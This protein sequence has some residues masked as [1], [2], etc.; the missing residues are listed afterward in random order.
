MQKTFKRAK[1]LYIAVAHH[2]H[3]IYTA[4]FSPLLPLLIDKLQIP[5]SAVAV[6]H[7]ARN[8]PSLLNPVLALVAERR[9]V[10]YFVIF[11]PAVTAISMSLIG[12][13]GSYFF[14]MLLLLIAGFSAALFHIPSPVMIRDVS[15]DRVGTGMSYFMVG[16]ELARTV[17]PIV[18]TA[19]VSWWALEGIA[20]LMPLGILTS[21]ILYFGLRNYSHL[22]ADEKPKP[23]AHS[24]DILK[25]YWTFFAAIALYNL[26]NAGMKTA[27]TLY[28]PVYLTG[29]G[30]SL[31][32]AGSSLALLQGFGVVGVF[33][34]G[35]IS[36]LIGRRWTLGV[37]SAGTVV[38]MVLFS[39]TG[40]IVFLCFLGFFLFASGPVLMAAVQD[41]DTAMPTFMN[42]LYM[43]INFGVGSLVALAVGFLGDSVGLDRTYLY[44]ALFGIGLVP[45]SLLLT[46]LN[47][48]SAR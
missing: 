43:T 18:A 22:K 38:F 7:V 24:I 35:R 4:F 39:L 26:F 23:A 25:E 36:D 5:L 37:S 6:L 42:G 1:V 9:G 40:N 14:V 31:W 21:V 32:F 13:A 48:R 16:G 20:R 17:G 44:T 15:G 2:I 47:K 33:L 30:E 41:T 29:R 3:D 34:S 27:L 11:A 10:K 28:L 19:A 46:G 45:A 8:V 12:V